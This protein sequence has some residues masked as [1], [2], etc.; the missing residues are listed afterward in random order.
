MDLFNFLPS[1]SSRKVK[2]NAR[3]PRQTPRAQL[4]LEN[5]EARLVMDAAAISGFVYADTNNNG[6]FDAGEKAIANSS[7]QLKNSQGTVIG[8]TVTDANGFY[9]FTADST[10]STAPALLAKSATIPT[11][12]TDWTQSVSVSQFDPS[13]GTL[14]SIDV[15]NSG[16]FTSSIKVESLTA[17]HRPLWPRCRGR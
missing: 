2:R 7:I 15:V 3:K 4:S 5:L 10:I 9:Q 13:L 11:T 17:A 6:L 1:F 14:T 8:Q 12:S 16:T